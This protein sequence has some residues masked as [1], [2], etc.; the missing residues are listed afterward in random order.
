[1][2]GPFFEQLSVCENIFFLEHFTD[3]RIDESYYQY[4]LSYFELED[5]E[6]NAV[7]HLSVGQRERVNLIR[8]CVHKPKIVLLD[9]P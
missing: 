2:D 1:M 7:I 3:I 5:F 4:L 9:E 8:A 6:Q